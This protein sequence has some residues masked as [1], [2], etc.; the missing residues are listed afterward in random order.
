MTDQ[1]GRVV[2]EDDDHL[3]Q[4]PSHERFK[5]SYVGMAHIAGTGPDGTHCHMCQHYGDDLGNP[6]GR[7]GFRSGTLRPGAKKHG[8]CH[9]LVD[10]KVFQKFTGMA[11]SCSLY[12]PSEDQSA[13]TLPPPHRINLEAVRDGV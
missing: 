9:R 4:E 10:G 5:D 1:F 8:Y 6:V 2:L 13:Y 11:K 3:T 12:D 7:F